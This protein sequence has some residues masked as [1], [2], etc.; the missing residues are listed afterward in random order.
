[1]P[2]YLQCLQQ[3]QSTIQISSRNVLD[4]PNDYKR[5]AVLVPIYIEHDE[6]YI[7]F[8]RRTEKVTHHKNEIS[9]PGGGFD[10][11]ADKNIIETAIR[12][13]EEEIGCKNVEILGLLDDIFTITG[14]I[15]TPVVGKITNGV[16]IDCNQQN[17]DEIQYVISVPLKKVANPSNFWTQEFHYN[18]GRLYQVPFFDCEGEIIWGATGRILLNFLRILTNLTL[19]CRE[20]FI[21]S[22]VWT[23]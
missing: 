12:E 5:A 9:F 4:I 7:L 21:S 22:Y 14:Y 6:W 13:I 16:D 18:G 8:T 15:V 20:Q 11:N 3:L 2:S 10:E 17:S 1:M 23:D 19:K